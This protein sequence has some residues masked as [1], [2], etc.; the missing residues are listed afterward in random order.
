LGED[1]KAQREADLN[2]NLDGLNKF[3]ISISLRKS[4][5]ERT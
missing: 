5:R 1:Q 4:W 2:H 3:L